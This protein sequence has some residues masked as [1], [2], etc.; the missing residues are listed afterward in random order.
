MSGSQEQVPMTVMQYPCVIE[1]KVFVRNQPHSN[2]LV[3]KLI[4]RY[5]ASEDVY[6]VSCRQSRKGTYQS[7][8]CRILAREREQ[9][10]QLYRALGQH[11][12]VLM[13][14]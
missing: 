2:R 12:D 13:S 4:C 3:R 9:M 1:I 6:K 7:Y 11:P 10:D 8:S 14:L 5:I